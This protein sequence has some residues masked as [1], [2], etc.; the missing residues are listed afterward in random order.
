M[1]V[2]SLSV[3]L[4]ANTAS[5]VTEINKANAEAKRAMREVQ[6]EVKESNHSLGLMGETF[7]VHIPRHIRT[8]VSELPGVSKAMSAAF[9]G[10]AILMVIKILVE[11]GTK[12]K[13]FAE[14]LH[15]M[16]AKAEEAKRQSAEAF[17]SITKEIQTSNDELLLTDIRL[18]NAIAKLE[19]KPENKLAEAL[20]EANVEAN[21][22]S[23]SLEDVFQKELDVLKGQNA[24]TW[25]QLTGTASNESVQKMASDSKQGI[26]DIYER[27]Y[28]LTHSGSDDDKQYNLE[29][30]KKE[31]SEFVGKKLAEAQG[32]LGWAQGEQERYDKRTTE[33]IPSKTGTPLMDH[34]GEISSIKSLMGVLRG[35]SDHLGLDTKV[36]EDKEKLGSLK[37]GK[38]AA[39]EQMKKFE[40][41]LVKQVRAALDK[42]EIFSTSQQSEFWHAALT[43]ALPVNRNAITE[44]ANN[45]DKELIEKTASVMEQQREEDIKKAAEAIKKQDEAAKRL[46]E[47]YNKAQEAVG[48][49]NAE[50]LKGMKFD[51]EIAA[52]NIAF[53]ESTGQI[54]AQD[55]AQQ[56]LTLHTKEYNDEMA[57][58]EQESKLITDWYL[59]GNL[60]DSE[61]EAK[62]GA[63]QLQ[64]KQVK[65]NYGVQHN[66]DEKSAE[67]AVAQFWDTVVKDG[68]NSQQKLANVMVSAQQGVNQQISALIEGQ[69]T[70]WAGL[71]KSIGN[72]LIQTS[73]QMAEG[74]IFKS[75]GGSLH[76]PGFASGGDPDPYGTSIVGENGPELFTPRGVAGTVSPNSSLSKIFGSGQ[77]NITNHIDARG[78]N[79]ADVDRRVRQGSLQAYQQAIKDSQTQH[80]EHNA[81]VPAHARS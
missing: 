75:L 79:A 19:R 28:D 47:T 11:A 64:Q 4:K 34:T 45:A 24:G 2:A 36:S 68:Q 76:I 53:K 10:L 71:F 6:A 49:Y 60:T 77:P 40:E 31:V 67:G 26:A 63:N 27:H 70:S 42:G 9:D 21:K 20:A 39:S 46:G 56:R 15:E 78:T 69:K 30:Q 5:F 29:E 7:G 58:L 44:K 8:F 72:M 61:A 59:S 66:A 65:G 33:I 81:R 12:L 73:L 48:K 22:L 43:K 38:D 54:S 3:N 16:G 32:Y 80:T 41:D 50:V 37:G 62:W 55:A 74:G 1:A 13:E 25:A 18:K 14:Y 51:A 17:Q 23:K 57:F 35:E 52:K